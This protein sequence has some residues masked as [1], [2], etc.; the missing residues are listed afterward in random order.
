[1]AHSKANIDL[2]VEVFSEARWSEALK[3]VVAHAPGGTFCADA[4]STEVFI[5]ACIR[6]G[7]V[8]DAERLL[9][10]FTEDFGMQLTSDTIRFCP[11][12]LDFKKDS[13]GPT[14]GSSIVPMISP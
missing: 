14:P 5:R 8:K 7:L 10:T 9:R 2:A 13:F 12:L 1:M 6:F 4:K 11:P 3:L